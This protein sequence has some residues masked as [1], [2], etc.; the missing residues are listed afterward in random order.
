[1]VNIVRQNYKKNKSKFNKIKRELKNNLGNVPIYHVGS[2]C[3][4]KMYGKNIIDIL[5]GVVNLKELK[6][7]SIKLKE[8]GFYISE[9]S[10]TDEYHF[11]ASTKE[12]T[13]SGDIH[14]H[15]VII[16]TNRYEDFLILKQYL[17]SFPNIAQMY[18]QHKKYILNNISD[19]REDYKD[20][21]SKYVTKLLNEAREF[22]KL[23]LSLTMIRHGENEYIDNVE[24]NLLPLSEAGKKKSEW[25]SKILKNDFDIIISSNSKRALETAKIISPRKKIIEDI[26]LIER[27]WGN[28]MHDG[29]ETDDEA[30]ERFKEFINEI[31]YKYYNKRVLLVFH[32]GLMKLAQDVIE[33]QILKRESID[34]CNIIKYTR[35]SQNN[36]FVSHFF[37]SKGTIKPFEENIIYDIIQNKQ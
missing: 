24:N 30:R 2:T 10:R 36:N 1:M 35:C 12:E 9:A 31:I 32:G 26:R 4:P 8:L 37:I 6:K 15:L 21:K 22:N 5:I 16:N 3:I 23:P 34:N 19:K 17:L 13:K 28:E 18:S 11:F 14:I 25:A 33:N 20:I 29:T 27:G 7:V